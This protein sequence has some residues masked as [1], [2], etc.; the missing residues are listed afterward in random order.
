MIRNDFDAY[1]DKYIEGYL[2]ADLR[3][4]INDVATNR[5]PGNMAY[6]LMVAVCSAMEFLGLLLR[7]DSP[8]KDGRIDASHGFGHYVK[9]I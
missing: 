5:H 9:T 3:T 8:V 7:D 2:F 1:I 6:L 4:I